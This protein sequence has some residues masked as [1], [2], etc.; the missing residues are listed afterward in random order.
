[1]K[2]YNLEIS[3]NTL[4]RVLVFL[5]I[6]LLFSITKEALGVLFIAIVVSLAIDPAVSWLEKKKIN[7]ILGTL[8]VF[9]L[10]ILIFSAAVYFVIPAI[11]LEA[12]GF[13]TSVNKTFSDLFGFGIPNNV[14]QSLSSNLNRI[15]SYISENGVSI[16]GT[17]STVLKNFVFFITTIIISFH[18][19]VE[20]NGTERLLKIILPDM[21]EKPILKV[22][23]RFKRK[24][25][26]WSVAQLSLSLLIGI[27][28]ALGLWMM[29]VKYAI[30]LGLLAAV[31]ELA[32][33]IGPIISGL[34]AFLV[35]MSS[36][37]TLGIYVIIFFLIVQQLENNILVPMVYKKSMKIHPVIV[38]VALLA[39]GNAA[40]MIG[41]ILSVPIAL[42]L[43]EA[44]NYIAEKKEAGAKGK[45]NI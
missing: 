12:Q 26:F 4:W 2:N 25:R 14:I 41:V 28:V 8:I 30:V 13:I 15:L 1:M 43:Q 10:I 37:F 5:G 27:I 11:T 16:T 18:L 31:F 33:V 20:N 45:L 39:G 3:W 32:P 34:V 9:F 36:S 6:I 38:L 42:L 22:F 7:R 35:A 19:S 17:I 44:F 21:Y 24:M 29:G 23:K 40:G